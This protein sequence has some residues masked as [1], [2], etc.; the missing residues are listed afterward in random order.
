MKVPEIK[1]GEGDTMSELELHDRLMIL[2]LKKNLTDEEK[3]EVNTIINNIAVNWELFLGK[4]CF[5]RV[6]GMVY[7]NL[8]AFRG[9]PREVKMAL[10]MLYNAQIE[11]LIA[12][13]KAINE[14]SELFRENSIK[15]A[16]LKGS[17]LNTIIYPEGTRISNDTDILVSP[18]QI[19]TV[20]KLL[21]SIGFVQG[22]YNKITDTIEKS[23]IRRKMYLKMNTHEVQSFSR[24]ESSR[25]LHVNT[26]DINFKLS[27]LDEVE[28]TEHLL[29]NVKEIDSNNVRMYSLNWDYFFV[30]LASHLYREA[31]LA[32]KIMSGSD[33]H[34]YKFYD[35]Y[36]I[37]NSP[38]ISLDFDNIIEIAKGTEQLKAVYYALYAVEQIFSNTV[39]KQLF[40]KFK[41]DN[42][43]FVDEYVGNQNG[44][45]IYHWNRSFID[46]FFDY[47]RRLEINRNVNSASERYKEH[48]FST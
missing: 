34:F 47:K 26:I 7:R 28:V 17:I 35:F 33:M 32:T 43:D 46:R 16:F 9:V 29:N 1:D 18:K 5:N 20:E 42:Y 22:E 12:E 48:L 4:V 21:T 44:D 30:Q 2:L 36:M 15:H 41:F 24:L 10:D 31:K 40:L 37:M 25:F 39:S 27:A 8:R 6:N 19:N 11:K 13:K 45:E 38:V 14:V 3:K 23:S